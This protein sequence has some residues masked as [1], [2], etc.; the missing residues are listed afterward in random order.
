MVRIEPIAG[1]HRF[2]AEMSFFLFANDTITSRRAN[3]ELLEVTRQACDAIELGDELEVDTCVAAPNFDIESTP[4]AASWISS[5][6]TRLATKGLT[7]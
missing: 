4:I 5:S 6:V 7:E 1:Q 2:V 3:L